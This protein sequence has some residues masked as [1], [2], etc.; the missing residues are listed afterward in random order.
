MVIDYNKCITAFAAMSSARKS[1]SH[2]TQYIRQDNAIQ[3]IFKIVPT[4]KSDS[5]YFCN[6]P[7]FIMAV[8]LL[9]LN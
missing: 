5:R 1:H 2:Q 9:S 4:R 6:F 3:A 8:D 7:I